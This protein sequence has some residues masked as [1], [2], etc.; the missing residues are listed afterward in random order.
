M[1]LL[2]IILNQFE[3]WNF[4]KIV[5]LITSTCLTSQLRQHTSNTNFSETCTNLTDNE[6]EKENMKFILRA[7]WSLYLFELLNLF[8]I[9]YSTFYD[10]SVTKDYN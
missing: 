7:K 9:S 1:P 3:L 2:Y 6:Q 5:N 8:W 4:N 10:L